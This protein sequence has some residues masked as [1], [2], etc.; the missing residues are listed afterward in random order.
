MKTVKLSI[1]ILKTV[2]VC[3]LSFALLLNLVGIGKK[4]LLRERIPLTFGYGDAIVISGSMSPTILPGD[5]IILQ[6][7]ETYEVNDI[8]TFLSDSPVTHR[9]VEKTSGGYITQGDA[10]DS[11]DSEI[12]QSQVIGKVIKIIPDAGSVVFFFQSPLGLVI[13]L[14]GLFALIEAPKIINRRENDIP[15]RVKRRAER[16]VERIAESA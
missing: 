2:V 1:K 15:E 16:R 10:N 5:M 7:Q 11:R 4:L 14:L 9:I 6:K 3:A 13:L 8:V 12:E